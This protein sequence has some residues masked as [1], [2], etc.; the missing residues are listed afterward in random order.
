M[1]KLTHLLLAIAAISAGVFIAQYNSSSNDVEISGFAFPSP[2]QLSDVVL[3]DHDSTEFSAHWFKGKWTF[4]YMGYTFCPDACPMTMV[5]LDQLHDQLAETGD[6]DDDVAM[7]LISVDPERDT[8]ERLKNYVT[9]FNERFVGATG[10]DENLQKFARQVSAVYSIP[11]E[12]TDANYL[13]DHSSTI[14]LINPDAA[15]HAIF[16]PPQEAD[17]LANDFRLLKSIYN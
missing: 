17:K 16:T 1:T 9:H 3:V 10:K 12:R 15:I 7:M 4:I 6:L 14:V 8:P 2:K 11:E 5:I 13:V